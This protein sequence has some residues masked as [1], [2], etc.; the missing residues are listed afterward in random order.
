MTSN[1]NNRQDSHVNHRS[2]IFKIARVNDKLFAASIETGGLS[3]S[4]ASFATMT[5]SQAN[6]GTLTAGTITVTNL[7]GRY[8]YIAQEFT[9]S[10]G[11]VTAT[12]PYDDTVPDDSEGTS[13]LSATV[14]PVYA[15]SYLL[16]EA[17]SH[18]AANVAGLNTILGIFSSTAT[19]AVEVTTIAT[20]SVN[21]MQKI[22]FSYLAQSSSTTSRAFTLRIGPE[23]AGT[24]TINGQ[25][26]A[27]LLGGAAITK[28]RISE[29]NARA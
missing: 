10:V 27:R 12:I 9:A 5:A 20:A 14:Q 22:S 1:L 2:G 11:T 28:L 4:G 18:V 8:E 23:A 25:A 19:L 17:E 29:I 24:I 16:V 13:I 26:A 21:L 3:V 7:N 15:T 6:I